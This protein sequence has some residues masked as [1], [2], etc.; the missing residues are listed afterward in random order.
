MGGISVRTGSDPPRCAF[1]QAPVFDIVVRRGTGADDMASSVIRARQVG[2]WRAGGSRAASGGRGHCDDRG[3]P[4]STSRG[5][6]PR[7]QWGR[8]RR[9]TGEVLQ[10]MLRYIFHRDFIDP[11]Y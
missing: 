3:A 4:G 5:G 10:R 9:R 6:R 11:I 2:L 8:F 7:W 1:L